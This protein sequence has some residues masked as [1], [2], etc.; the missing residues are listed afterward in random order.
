MK[1]F[2]LIVMLM[3]IFGAGQAFAVPSRSASGRM[4][5]HG[6]VTEVDLKERTMTLTEY[7]TGRKYLV[8]VPA[9]SSFK[10]FAG[11][12]RNLSQPRLEDV[13]KGDYVDCKVR[14]EGSAERQARG[15]QPGG[16]VTVVVASTLSR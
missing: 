5:L 6:K 12:R 16:D 3:A 4:L 9:G 14:V 2:G 13:F 10:I 1:R 7:K 8:L 15:A 11:L